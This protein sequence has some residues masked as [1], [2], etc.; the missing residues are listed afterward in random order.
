MA[1][2]HHFDLRHFDEWWNESN[3]AHTN[4]SN[5]PTYHLGKFISDTRTYELFHDH[6]LLAMIPAHYRNGLRFLNHGIICFQK[7]LQ[8][9]R[10]AYHPDLLQLKYEIFGRELL[11]LSKIREWFIQEVCSGCLAHQP[12]TWISPIMNS[13]LAYM[14]YCGSV[15]PCHKSRMMNIVVDDPQTYSELEI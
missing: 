8:H 1:F 4:F 14:Y 5:I 12:E 7:L 3:P 2:S 6:E 11:V 10:P 9:P 15:N 13:F